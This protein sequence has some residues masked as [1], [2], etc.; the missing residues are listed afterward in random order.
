MRRARKMAKEKQ[1]MPVIC[2]S[3]RKSKKGTCLAA[4]SERTSA[5]TGT[6]SDKRT[7]MVFYRPFGQSAADAGTARLVDVC[8]WPADTNPRGH[9]YGKAEKVPSTFLLPID[10][11]VAIAELQQP[12]HA[13]L[14]RTA[15]TG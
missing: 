3:G 10:F 11:V 4:R 5:R 6:T 7:S 15:R 13:T 8:V 14:V 9:F 1:T 12:A 2:E